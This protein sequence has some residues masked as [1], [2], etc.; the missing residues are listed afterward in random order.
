MQQDEELLTIPEVAKRAKVSRVSVY[1][2]IKSRRLR[3]VKVGGIM[4]VPMSAWL[5]FVQPNE[6]IDPPVAA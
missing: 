3:T 1:T 5:E 6:Q 4:R 2:W